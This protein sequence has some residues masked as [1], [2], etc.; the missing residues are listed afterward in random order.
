MALLGDDRSSAVMIYDAGLR[1]NCSSDGMMKLDDRT[2]ME[3]CVMS[4][5]ASWC[6]MSDRQREPQAMGR[7]ARRKYNR[8]CRLNRD[9]VQR[10]AERRERGVACYQVEVGSDVLNMLVRLE[11]IADSDVTDHQKVET[12]LAKLLA[13]TAKNLMH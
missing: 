2:Y 9:R 5:S 1:Y 6:A 11:W 7:N 10:A 4:V 13:D 12:A 8:L 3:K